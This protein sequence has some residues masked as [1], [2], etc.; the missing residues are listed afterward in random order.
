MANAQHYRAFAVTVVWTLVLLT[1][2]SIVHA[3]ESS[4]ACPDWPTCFGT[5][6]PEMSGGVF[7]EHLHRLVA[8]GLIL[9]FG[10]ATWYAW[11]ETADRP[12]IVWTAL[13]GMVLLLIQA[14]LGGLTV[15]LRLPTAVSTAHLL[16]AL[17]F[18]TLAVVLATATSPR[19]PHRARPGRDTTVAL[20]GWGTAAAGLVLLQSLVGGMV[21]HADA[22]MAC[23]DLPTCLG[24]WIPPLSNPLVALHFTHRALAMLLTGVIVVLAVR[25]LRGSAPV[26]VRRMMAIVLM[27]LGVQWV[28]GVISVTSLLAVAPVSLHTLGGASLL[29]ALAVMS[30]WGFLA[31]HEAASQRATEAVAATAR[32]RPD[33]RET[34]TP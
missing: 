20:R 11:R 15:I 25:V 13:A 17:A 19:R 8:G 4:L 18:L 14:V 31:G 26:H 7:W 1:L 12:W 22:G 6:V 24:E 3:T 10:L 28:L 33:G 16:M 21:R 27:L 34:A 32:T 2:G 9:M 23:P 29:C 5:M 30:T